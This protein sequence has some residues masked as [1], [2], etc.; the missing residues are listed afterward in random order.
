MTTFTSKKVAVIACFLGSAIALSCYAGT[1]G[2]REDSSPDF[3]HVVNLEGNGD[4]IKIVEVRGPSDTLAVGNIYEVRGTYKLVSQEKALLMVNLTT[5][6]RSHESH[7]SLAQQKIIVEKGE[8]SFVLQFH[9]WEEGMP[10]VS[11]YPI[12]GG[13]GFAARYF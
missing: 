4:T 11:F 3:S 5:E 9:L 10:H 1:T 7:P 8:G 13:N 12:N 2:R 6:G